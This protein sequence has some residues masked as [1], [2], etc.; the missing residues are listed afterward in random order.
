MLDILEYKERHMAFWS[1]EESA[2]PLVGFTVGAGSDSWSYWKYN[3]AAK[4]LYKNQVVTPANLSPQNFV[5]GQLEYLE[6][7]A[8]IN[9]DV[10]RSAMPLASIP[11]M[12]A[13]LGCPVISSGEHL[14][15]EPLSNDA[16]SID[17]HSLDIHN[18]W[19]KKYMEFMDVYS[20]GFGEKYPVGQSIIRGISDL[21]NALI[22]I[23]NASIGLLASPESMHKLFDKVT[24]SLIEFF[25]LQQKFLPQFRDGYVIGQYE[26]WAPEYPVRIQ[27]DAAVFY[28]PELFDEFLKERV[29][30]IAGISNYTLIHLHSPAMTLI[31]NFLEINQIDAFQ[32]TKDP[33]SVTLSEMISALVKIQEKGR[34]LIVKGELN[35]ED[36]KLLKSN[37]SPSGLCIQPVVSSHNDAKLLLSSLRN[38]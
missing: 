8:R 24:G 9:D 14:T 26:I 13:I 21:G 19:I 30:E 11:W 15:I 16:E 20:T 33:G 34:P 36:I 17:L 22:G 6:E 35:E 2:R 37:L 5:D 4:E 7:S 29:A 1:L 18:E 23:E 27:E 25:K 38:W 10:C 32:V 12:E 28:S 3:N 31:D